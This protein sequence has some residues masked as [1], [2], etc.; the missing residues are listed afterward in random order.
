MRIQLI[1]FIFKIIL[2]KKF[3]YHLLWLESFSASSSLIWSLRV[4]CSNQL[5]FWLLIVLSFRGEI[6]HV[7]SG[8]VKVTFPAKRSESFYHHLGLIWP[9][10][11]TLFTLFSIPLSAPGIFL[12]FFFY[13]FC[14]LLSITSADFQS[15]VHHVWLLVVSNTSACLLFIIR[16]LEIDF[17]FFSLLNALSISF[18]LSS[19]IIEILEASFSIYFWPYVSQLMWIHII[20]HFKNSL[21]QVNSHND[22]QKIPA[23]LVLFI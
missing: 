19:G 16:V 10:P 12:V 22:I 13:F 1:G 6:Y 21:C 11:S 15:C 5:F 17:R 7:I 9:S 14:H 4:L 2:I 8:I 3:F 18:G 20:Y 23:Y